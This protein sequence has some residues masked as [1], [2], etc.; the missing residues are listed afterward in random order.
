MEKEVVLL[1]SW[2]T[3]IIS[4]IVNNKSY[5]IIA[6]QDTNG[7]NKNNMRRRRTGEKV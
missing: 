3:Y 5:S 4:L 1:V 7:R 2:C 6:Y